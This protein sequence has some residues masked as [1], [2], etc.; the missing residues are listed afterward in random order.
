MSRRL[1]TLFGAAAI[2]ASCAVEPQASSVSVTPLPGPSDPLAGTWSTGSVSFRDVRAAMLAAGLT[3]ADFVAWAEGQDLAPWPEDPAKP[4]SIA[5]ELRFTT[6]G[7]WEISVDSGGQS[8][9]VVDAGTFELGDG[10]L[11]LTS[12]AD[13]DVGSF[14]AALETGSLTLTLLGTDEVGT[15]EAAYI[16][17]LYAVALFTSAP[18]VRER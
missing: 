9:G 12:D 14:D 11:D 1:L 17:Q 18:F 2:V 4:S 16:H 5:M 10:Q 6:D 3:D 7:R 13:G 8:I 15:T